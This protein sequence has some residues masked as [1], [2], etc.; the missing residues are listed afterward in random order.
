MPPIALSDHVV[1]SLDQDDAFYGQLAVAAEAEQSSS[2]WDS[3]Q[4]R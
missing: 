4:I 2:P 3:K 1:G